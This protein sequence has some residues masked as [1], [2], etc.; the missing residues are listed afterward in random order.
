MPARAHVRLWVLV[1]CFVLVSA[2]SALCTVFSL[3]SLWVVVLES[4]PCDKV[5]G[6]CGCDFLGS[7]AGVVDLHRDRGCDDDTEISEL[8]CGGT[9]GLDWLVSASVT[10]LRWGAKQGDVTPRLLSHLT[11]VLR[12]DLTSL[13]ASSVCRL[14]GSV[15]G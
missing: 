5:Q 8:R 15:E 7:F 14:R 1:L 11:V 13:V 4:R 12:R 10:Q 9:L 2:L 6:S 3:L